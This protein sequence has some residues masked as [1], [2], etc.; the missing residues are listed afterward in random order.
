MTFRPEQRKWKQAV[1]ASG[2]APA[3][4]PGEAFA[5]FAEDDGFTT[6]ILFAGHRPAFMPA[7]HSTMTAADFER[8]FAARGRGSGGIGAGGMAT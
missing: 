3:E 2:A 1:H 6:G 8:T 7:R 5:R 4:H